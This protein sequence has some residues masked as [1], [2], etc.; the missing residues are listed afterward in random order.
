MYYWQKSINSSHLHFLIL[1]FANND[2]SDEVCTKSL[3][4]GK[5]LPHKFSERPFNKLTKFTRNWPRI[6]RELTKNWPYWPGLSEFKQVDCQMVAFTTANPCEAVA[7]GT[8]TTKSINN[9]PRVTATD[10]IPDKT[11]IRKDPYYRL[12]W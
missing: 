3:A 4:Q 12:R 1:I 7:A 2:H 8:A 5:L 6:D 11:L 10:L 9:K